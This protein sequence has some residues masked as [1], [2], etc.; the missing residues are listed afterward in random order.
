MTIGIPA[1]EAATIDVVI[2][3][4]GTVVTLDETPAT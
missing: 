3:S 1:N 2:I 4:D